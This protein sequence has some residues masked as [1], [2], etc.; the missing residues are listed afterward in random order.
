[1][2]KLELKEYYFIIIP[3]I[4]TILLYLP[5]LFFEFRNFDEDIMIKNIYTTKTFIEHWEKFS[6]LNLMGV[7]YF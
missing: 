2:K 4:I 1:M 5:S 7:S 3:L 6:F